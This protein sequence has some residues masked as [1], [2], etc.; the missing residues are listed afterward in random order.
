MATSRGG[1][2]TGGTLNAGGASGGPDGA[3]PGGG[4]VPGGDPGGNGAGR[5]P[6]VI[7]DGVYQVSRVFERLFYCRASRQF[8]AQEFPPGSRGRRALRRSCRPRGPDR[9]VRVA[10]EAALRT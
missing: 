1:I 4:I 6:S 3:A 5:S 9:S 10:A 7:G 2:A 8:S